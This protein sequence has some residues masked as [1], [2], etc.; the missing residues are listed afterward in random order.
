M[1]SYKKDNGNWYCSFYYTDYQGNRKKKKKEGFKTKRESEA[2]EREYIL[3]Y[4]GS[5]EM[6]FSSLYSL[7]LDDS[8]TRVKPTTYSNKKLIIDARILPYFK[9][10]SIDK[11]TPLDIRRWQ[12]S[13]IDEQVLY[14]NRQLSEQ[15]INKLKRILSAIFNFAIKYYNLSSNP[16]RYVDNLKPQGKNEMNIWTESEFLSFLEGL[17][18]RQFKLPFLILFYCGLRKGELYALTWGDIDL[19]RGSI[20]INKTLGN[21]SGEGEYIGSPKTQESN[22]IVK[23]PTI[24]VDEFKDYK[25][26]TYAIKEHYRI[27]PYGDSTY[28]DRL[29]KT[30]IKQGLPPIRLHDL[31]HSHI[32]H[33]IHLGVDIVTISKRAG[34][35]KP[36]I[37]LDVYG[38]LYEN[39][40]DSVITALDKSTKSV[41]KNQK[42][43]KN[44]SL[45]RKNTP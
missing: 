4:A 5:P 7:Y 45:C 28:A 10:K 33:L 18:E 25:S 2:W 17:D 16:C 6:T 23:M 42:Q 39:T 31:R 21:I 11:I 12:N 3:K 36:S 38:H 1:P 13:L 34:H 22:R 44:K 8:K 27:F 30:A 35:S 43:S 41:L 20:N 32:S 9:D 14:G 37:T 24:V 19:E 26:K 40:Q 29:E 15:Y